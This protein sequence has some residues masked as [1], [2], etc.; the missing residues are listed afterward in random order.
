[1]Q[2]NSGGIKKQI[3]QALSGKE[4]NLYES[5]PIH[6]VLSGQMKYELTLEEF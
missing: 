6:C 1:M 2:L 3:N 4:G 5:L